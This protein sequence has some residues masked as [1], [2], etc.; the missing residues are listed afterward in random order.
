MSN[1]GAKHDDKLRAQSEQQADF[2]VALLARIFLE[3]LSNSTLGF[4]WAAKIS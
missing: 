4:R 3:N 2:T 1:K